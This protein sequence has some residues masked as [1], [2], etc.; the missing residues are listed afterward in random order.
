MLLPQYR[1]EKMSCV[2]GEFFGETRILSI[3]FIFFL[4]KIIA[5]Q[6]GIFRF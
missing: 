4:D 2:C 1:K 6:Q 5:F 3:I